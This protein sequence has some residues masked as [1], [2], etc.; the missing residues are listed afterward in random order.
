MRYGAVVIANIS[1]WS[2][3]FVP[4]DESDSEDDY[5]PATRT[6]ATLDVKKRLA[7]MEQE[8]Q[9]M[10]KDKLVNIHSSLEIT[11]DQVNNLDQT[12]QKQEG[13]IKALEK[14]ILIL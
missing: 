13:R 12:L 1:K 8:M 6:L 7:D 10:I 11:S 9:K 14:K 5:H 2:S 3:F 4:G